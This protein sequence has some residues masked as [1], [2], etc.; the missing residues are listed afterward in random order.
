MSI[1][2]IT[3]TEEKSPVD[4]A[5]LAEAIGIDENYV[6]ALKGIINDV[7]QIREIG[8]SLAVVSRE[9]VDELIRVL[10]LNNRTLRLENL[11][12]DGEVVVHPKG[13]VL[14]RDEEGD[15]EPRLMI[16]LEPA[17]LQAIL[18]QLIPKLKASL[19][20]RKRSDEGLLGD[21]IKIRDPLV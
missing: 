11:A 8:Q 18:R 14:I 3:K 1:E 5:Q 12:E 10:Q 9:I 16:D 4:N 17:F 20:D 15:I 13:F 19:D 7:E 6:K 21:L 2:V